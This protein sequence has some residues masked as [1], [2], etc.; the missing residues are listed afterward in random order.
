MPSGLDP[1]ITAL[2][3]RIAAEIASTGPMSFS[4]F[5]ELALYDPGH[6]YYASGVGRL[7]KAGDFFTASDVGSAFAECLASQVV[8]MDA[9]LG[10]PERFDLLEFGAGRGLLARDVLDSIQDLDPRLAERLGCALV[11]ASPAMREEAARRVPEARIVAP[12]DVGSGH[13]GCIVAVE[14]FDALPVH[15]LRRRG[16]RLVEVFVGC[17]PGGSLVEVER[18]TL[19]E[20]AALAERYGAA[21]REGDEAE[22]SPAS[23]RMLDAMAGTLVRGFILVVDYGYPADELYGPA[24]PRGT[25]LAYHRHSTSEDYLAR[26]GEQDLTA[27]VN[28]TALEDRARERGLRVL[29]RTTQDRFLVAT[30]I[31]ERLREE[32][33]R[34]E[35]DP[36]LVKRRLQ[37]LQLLH[38]EGMGRAFK[39]LL[40]SKDVDPPAELAGLTDPFATRRD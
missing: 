11:D 1:R 25:L 38:P 40:I 14:L 2:T 16:G 20:A 4:R 7:G 37:A 36:R 26:A 23:V 9:R 39:I 19:P 21:A 13:T 34:R 12:D 27:H 29:G 18:P 10:R 33:P 35:R 22:V 3:R 30:G 31:L 17:G 5:M 8:E 15:R 28:F 32:D 24:H 6:G